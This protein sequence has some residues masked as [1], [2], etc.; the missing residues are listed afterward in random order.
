M[1]L[2][3]ALQEIAASFSPAVLASSL[4]AE[5]MVLTDLIARLR[6][7]IEVFVLDTGRLHADTLALIGTIRAAYGMH[8]RVYEPDALAAREYVQRRGRDAFYESIELRKRCCE[9]RKLEPLKR[10]LTGKRAW[11]TGQRRSHGVTRADLAEREYDAAHGL[12]KFNPLA[13]WSEEQVWAYIAD[14][15]VPYNRLYE[16][17]YRSIGCAP[18]TRPILPGEDLRAGRWW[19]EQPGQ[20]ECGLHANRGERPI[21]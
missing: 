9:I 10:A 18:C 13:A 7:P 4:S 20:R 17:G 15:G 11:I 2:E 3:K 8:V 1:F 21:S 19:W 14:R 12:E 16:Q 5:D 6:L